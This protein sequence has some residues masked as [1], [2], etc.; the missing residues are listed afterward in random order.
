[1]GRAMIF[2]L[3][4]ILEIIFIAQSTSFQ[5]KS[6]F[7]SLADDINEAA[8]QAGMGPIAEVEGDEDEF[9]INKAKS[10]QEI[11]SMQGL[12]DIQEI[13]AMKE[14]KSIQEVPD[15]VAE[16]FISDND[17]QPIDS[18]D[19]E[20]DTKSVE[21]Y[22]SPEEISEE[23]IS[24]EEIYNASPEAAGCGDENTNQMKKTLRQLR[25]MAVDMADLVDSL[26]VS[27]SEP[28]SEPIPSA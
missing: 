5:L 2:Q 26:D 9:D 20:P 10:M 18:L 7:A 4:F 13:T 12:K 6:R 24:E 3:C 14:I 23:E 17:L 16:K 15:D 11:K 22:N 19:D 25:D 28:E 8:Q 1:M 21:D 27:E